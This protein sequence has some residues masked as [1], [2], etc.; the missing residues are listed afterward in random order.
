MQPT[1]YETTHYVLSY[2]FGCINLITDYYYDDFLS[3]WM[4]LKT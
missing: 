2:V 3:E 4:L 1:K